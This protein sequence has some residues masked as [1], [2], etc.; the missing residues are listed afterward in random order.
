VLDL[1][2]GL[3]DQSLVTLDDTSGPVTR[4]RMLEPIRQYGEAKLSAADKEKLRHRHV[5]HWAAAYPAGPLKDQANWDRRARE[6]I[7]LASPDMTNMTAAI[8]WA[9]AA[10]RY[11]DAMAI[12]GGGLGLVLEMGG[13]GFDS[14][15]AWLTEGI[16]H[17][18]EMPPEV[19][20]QATVNACT[21]AAS[22]GHNV[23]TMEWFRIAADLAPTT[24]ERHRAEISIAVANSRM[25]YDDEA[26]AML[27]RVFAESD[28]P[29]TK[30]TVLFW[31]AE[32][33]PASEEWELLQEAQTYAPLEDLDTHSEAFAWY[34]VA[35]VADNTGRY[36]EAIEATRKS[37]EA[38]R[39]VGHRVIETF[40]GTLLARR[41]A[42]VGRDDEAQ[43]IL[44]EAVPLLRRLLGMNLFVP[45]VFCWAANCARAIGNLEEAGELIDEA[46]ANA[47]GHE[48]AALISHQRARLARDAGDLDQADR[49]LREAAHRKESLPPGSQVVFGRA[50]CD[51]A[52][53][54]AIRRKDHRD[55][56]DRLRECLS[57]DDPH[58]AI[59]SRLDTAAIALIQA[60]RP[61]SGAVI[62]GFVDHE[63]ERTGLVIPPAD[64][65][66]RRQTIAAGRAALGSAWKAAART[67]AAMTLDEAIEYVRDQ[68]AGE[69]R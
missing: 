36:D 13:H 60:G 59:I 69:T 58:L 56:L 26:S 28:D 24:W 1:Q 19:L 18:D 12:L 55:A 33:S 31:K 32:S 4:Y 10:G 61:E 23:D 17:A 47:V 62:L 53:S 38:A 14:V 64:R 40:G 50:I 46:E 42:A 29:R 37:V 65:A 25:G 3:L 15:R 27:D 22:S 49:H 48:D 30:G 16:R 63:R 34:T 44:A 9:L 2:T 52:A 5:D 7:P 41:L 67:G 21:V 11:G 39:R 51:T 54:I 35:R 45:M 68:I 57:S 8:G 20:Y 43:T 66:I 6:V